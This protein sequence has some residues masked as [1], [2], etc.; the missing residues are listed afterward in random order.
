MGKLDHQVASFVG[1]LRN[2]FRLR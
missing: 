2:S 1:R